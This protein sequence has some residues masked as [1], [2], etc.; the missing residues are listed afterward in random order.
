METIYHQLAH[1]LLLRKELYLLYLL[2]IETETV[3]GNYLP[4]HRPKLLLAKELY[5]LFLLCIETNKVYAVVGSDNGK[6][7]G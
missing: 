2:Y 7:V 3:Y 6:F 1:K 5:R 4:L